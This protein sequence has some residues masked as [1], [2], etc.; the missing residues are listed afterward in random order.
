MIVSDRFSPP[1]SALGLSRNAVI[2]GGVVLFHVAALWALQS[3]LLRRAAEVVIP[4][5]I[6]SEFIEPPK[7]KELPPPPPPP[8]PEPK[9]VVT[10]TPPPPRPQAIRE[11]KPTP[12]PNAPTG[13]IEPPPPPAPPAPPAP[14]EPPAPP[15]A[16]PAPPSVQLPSSNADYLQNPKPVY[17][18]M[19]KRLGEQ[20]K[21]IVRVLI[22]VDGLPKQATIRQSSGYE[23]L[24]EAARTAVMGWRYVPGK[25]NGVVEPMEFNVPINWVLN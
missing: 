5:E 1:P 3:G 7:P 15:P 9:R 16:P 14:P 10:K 6:L 4:V 21:T 2:A 24:D 20:G 25:R 18:A 8:P 11:L 17:P 19:S 13:S 22:G 12:A 23:R